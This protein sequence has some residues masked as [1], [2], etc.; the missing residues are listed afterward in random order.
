M[1]GTKRMKS[2]TLYKVT[3]TLYGYG[4]ESFYFNTE[5]KANAYA[6]CFDDGKVEKV[7]VCGNHLYYKDGFSDGCMWEDLNAISEKVI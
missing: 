3:S 7:K 2:M 5:I 1:R 4:T 6:S